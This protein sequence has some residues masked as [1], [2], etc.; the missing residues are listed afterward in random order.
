MKRLTVLLTTFVSFFMIANAQDEIQNPAIFNINKLAP[1]AYFI[2]FETEQL[3]CTD[4]EYLSEYFKSLN[5][6]WKFHLSSNPE[7]RPVDFFKDE[8]TVSQWDNINVPGNWEIQGFDTAIYVNT[9]Y[10]F[11]QIEGINPNPPHIPTSY[12]PVGS[13][14]KTFTIPDNW[15]N[16]R[17]IIHIGAVKSAYYIWINGHKVGYSE[18][19]KTPSEF[20]I[21]E[22]IT[23]GNNTIA[24]EVYRWST[25]SYLEAQDFWRLSGIERDV[26]LL[27]VP[28]VRIRDFFVVA[29]LDNNYLNGEFSLTA[30]IEN[31]RKERA[32][33]YT[34]DILV[35]RKDNDKQIINL[36]LTK[37]IDSLSNNFSFQTTVENPDHWSAEQPNLYT[38]L[39]SLKDSKGNLIQAV[40]QDIGFRTAE[41]KNGQFLVNGKAVLV[42]GVNRHEHDPD[43]GHVV[44]RESMLRD[45]QLMK[46]FNIN[47]VRTCHYPDHP[48][49]YELCD[50]YGIYVIDEANIESHGMGY[51]PE[52]LAKHEEWGPMH[53]DRTQRMVERDKNHACIVTWSLGNEGGDGV[54]FIATSQWIH[55]RDSSRPVQY[56][57]AGL[58]SHTDIYCPMYASTTHMANYAKTNPYRPLILCEYAH[59]MGNSCGGLQD[60]WDT[61]SAYK[62]LQGG[63]IWDWVDQ[64]LRTKDDNGRMFYAYGGDFGENMPSDN[65]F[66]I[67]GLVNPDRIPNPQLY[68][69]KK[70]YQN[71]DI[72]PED[73]SAGK[74][75]IINKY[76][77]TNLD[78]FI[79][80]WTISDAEGIVAHG[81]PVT[82]NV[83]P[84]SEK[85]FTI[86]LPDLAQP[87]AGQMYVLRFTL[88]TKKRNGLVM[89]GH[90]QAWAEF[91]LNDKSKGY[92]TPKQTGTVTL[93]EKEGNK[94]IKGDNFIVMINNETGLLTS[95]MLKGKELLFKGPKL[96]FFR[97]PTE[98]DIPD[99]NGY[100]RWHEAGLDEL[101]QT[102][103]TP[104]ILSPDN[105][106]IVMIYPL[107]LKSPSTNINAIMQYE[108]MPDGTINISAEANI[109]NQ[110]RAIAKAGLQTLMLRNF[111]KISWYGLGG[112]STY[113]DRK[114][115]GRFGY[116]ATSASDMYNSTIVV[117]QDNCNQ[118][119]VQWASV[120]DIEGNGF[121]IRGT[122]PMNFSAYPFDDIE[123]TK[124]RH[125]NEL[126]EA[127][128]VTVNTDAVVTGLGTATCGPGIQPPYVA[129][130]GIYSFDMEFRPLDLESKSIF[131]V[132]EEQPVTEAFLV[133]N[134]PEITRDRESIVTITAGENSVIWYS[135][136]NGKFKKYKKP[137]NMYKGAKIV[138]YAVEK[139]KHNSLTITKIMDVNKAKWSA[140]ADSYHPGFPVSNAIDSDPSTF[141]HTNWNDESLGQPHFI[142]VDLGEVKNVAGI[143]YIPR[144]DGYYAS[145]GRIARYDVEVSSNGT[146]WVMV[147]KDGVFKD[148]K[149]RQQGLFAQPM[150]IRY[151][152]LTSKEEVEG[153]FFSS[154][155]E[156]GVVV[157]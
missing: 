23:K 34:V 137:F 129:G 156:V 98:N 65:S 42:K 143:D 138:A 141:W 134:P 9:T 111:D 35:S 135:V 121:F 26:Y 46:E 84:Q 119:D 107:T 126:D 53:M 48:L 29:G 81:N 37:A 155:G 108:F 55:Q 49:W 102:A 142:E 5:G 113:P 133:A 106:N 144:Q 4:N 118:M 139:G 101:Q 104:E 114:S 95:Y 157:E 123:I 127:D 44:S 21:T 57:R 61:I 152:R 33:D 110:V 30:D 52:S 112:V 62:S 41:M 125:I 85:S 150:D 38:M 56:E 96:N 8:Y 16:R 17:V 14:R 145:H 19:S 43:N 69:V 10:P 128:F 27:A 153:R 51:G 77:F 63:C 74:F 31:I 66:C 136:N 122:K 89:K 32:G 92:A 109:P 18:G 90:E 6:K 11:W 67:N 130:T 1:H 99:A 50:K 36:S 82:L 75:K 54:N 147:I 154:A 131:A 116:Y 151:F 20:D 83:D 79:L 71:I 45:I 39:I 40:K 146:D 22:F 28:D 3:A 59:A 2:P 148:I 140:K 25:G 70:V 64:G 97:P 47:T 78:E 86:H 76:F 88:N 103:D 105:G 12:N 80:N 115:G 24:L 100:N 68:E 94:V 87:K 72:V 73:I 58:E 124:A 13:Y 117:P 7:S 120:T 60:Y 93:S 132:A 149:D 15:D 91:I